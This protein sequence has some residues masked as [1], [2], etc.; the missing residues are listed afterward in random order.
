MIKRGTKNS[1]LVALEKISEDEYQ[2][3]CGVKLF[4]PNYAAEQTGNL[5]LNINAHTQRIFGECVAVPEQLV[6]GD[7]VKYE[8]GDYRF[9]DSIEPE[10]QIGD[11]VYFEYTCV[12]KGSLLE[13]EGKMYCNI[14]YASILCVVRF[15]HYPEYAT[16]EDG[17]LIPIGLNKTSQ[18]IPIGGNIICEEYWGKDA[19]FTEV[20][21]KRVFGEVSKSGLIT[22]IIK[23]PSQKEA[24]VKI[25]GKPLKGDKMELQ[26]G[27][28]IT[29][30]NKF[31]MPNNIEGKDYLFVK[32][33][34][35]HAVLGS[36]N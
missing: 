26:E 2:F 13:H 16:K 14:N 21:G 3:A 30:P 10:V 7:M 4:I 28:L 5:Q 17:G 31:G 27:D 8:E 18:I 34:D 36:E 24:V 22:N 23:K 1:V 9:V 20:G 15:G 25:I 29:F 33:W 12:N 11:R 35:I 32:Y 6:K 19:S